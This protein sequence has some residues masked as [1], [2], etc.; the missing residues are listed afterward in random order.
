M[1]DMEQLAFW[2]NVSLVV[3]ALQCVVMI[4]VLV[5]VNYALVRVMSTMQAKTATLARKTQVVSGTINERTQI[6]SRKAV[7]PVVAVN[8]RASRIYTF[9][10]ALIRPNRPGTSTDISNPQ[11]DKE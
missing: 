5:V 11:P 2:R 3:L 10:H 1:T 6:Y 9:L 7:A 4:V 8:L